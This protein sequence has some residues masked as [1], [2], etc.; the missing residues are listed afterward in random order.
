MVRY[1]WHSA[2]YT[3]RVRRLSVD[4]SC[5]IRRPAAFPESDTFDYGTRRRSL[6]KL[7]RVERQ[8]APVLPPGAP[9]L[10][11]PAPV[12]KVTSSTEWL[13]TGAPTSTGGLSCCIS[14]KT[15]APA[16]ST[17]ERMN[18]VTTVHLLDGLYAAADGTT[19]RR[20]RR[21]LAG[22]RHIRITRAFGA[23]SELLNVVVCI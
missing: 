7:R 5:R 12:S 3:R 17:R 14:T 18:A 20:C 23:T 22:D 16:C 6:D 19:R 21:F 2:S 11:V 4:R 15:T 9:A 10:P 1:P 8:S 13:R